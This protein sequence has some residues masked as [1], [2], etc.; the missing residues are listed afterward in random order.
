MM[1]QIVFGNPEFLYLLVIIP[2]LI[3][4]Y[5]I[6]QRKQNAAIRI[7]S[8]APFSG[9]NKP[10][11]FYFSQFLVIVR[12]AVFTLI[13]LVLARP[14]SANEWEISSAEGID[15]SLCM[16]VS[17][18]MKAMDF[19]PNRLEAAKDVAAQFINGR[20]GD[21]FA[22]VAFSGESFTLCPLTNDKAILINQMNNLK[23][24]MIED[25]TAIGMGLAT[26]VNRLRNSKAKSKVI[27]LLTD[28][29]NNRGSIGP[30]TA[31]EIAEQFGIR[32]YTIGVGS[33]GTAPMPV[34]TVFGIQTRDVEVE[35]DEDVLKD[36]AG[37]TGGKYFRATDNA[38][39]A[40]IYQEIDKLEKTIIDVEKFSKRKDE[41]FP[42]LLAACI[43][44]IIEI[45]LRITYLKNIP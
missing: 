43:L 25:G 15:I 32:V 40:M 5:L 42:Y 24:G 14:Q 6:R 36:I 41:Y 16:D 28:G 19:K 29:V 22:I 21:R 11:R 13:I 17:G 33:I 39:L 27:I 44:F 2:V 9:L 10:F 7:S 45:L 18:S 37:K 4:W 26:S 35:I 31:A 38:K 30:V 12:F 20:Q 34:Q 8:I 3:A 23:F 1:R